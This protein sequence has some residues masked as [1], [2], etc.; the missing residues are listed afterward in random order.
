MQT[1]FFIDTSSH[2]QLNHRAL[3]DL[4][5][6]PNN[7]WCCDHRGSKYVYQPRFHADHFQQLVES[8]TSLRNLLDFFWSDIWI[9]TMYQYVSVAKQDYFTQSHINSFHRCKFESSGYVTSATPYTA[10]PYTDKDLYDNNSIPIF[11]QIEFSCI[12]PGCGIPA[13]LDR[14]DKLA[15]IL[16]YLPTDLQNNHPLLG[17]KFWISKNS[18]PFC[19][20]DYS[21]DDYRF[22]DEL[23]EDRLASATNALI[24]PFTNASTVMFASNL[25]SWHSIHY[26]RD[27]NLGPRV[28]I[29]I[30]FYKAVQ[31]MKRDHFN[32][33][34]ELARQ[35]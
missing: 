33:N 14:Q 2:F 29:N 18:Q 6:L 17:T 35:I 9:N 7:N 26:P 11:P 5:L 15:S 30:N 22:L 10:T 20:E 8:S 19:P 13:H 25:K 21:Y 24:L 3:R 31:L 16:I 1:V 23:E 27:I 28:S 34:F 12:T 32:L 4:V